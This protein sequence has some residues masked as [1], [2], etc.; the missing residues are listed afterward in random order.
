[1]EQQNVG[2]KLC[3]L[4]VDVIIGGHPHVIEPAKTFTSTVDEN[5][6]TFCIYSTGNFLSNQRRE[7]LGRKTGDT[8]DGV[9]VYTTFTKYDTG[10]IGIEVAYTPTWIDKYDKD[11]KKIWEIVPL[12]DLSEVKRS[13]DKAKESKERTDKLLS[14]GFAS[15]NNDDYVIKK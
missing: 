12:D 7:E 5:H 10:E 11:G 8:E 3:D 6:K 14:S 9:I 15:F 1:M 4:G 13:A 2:Q